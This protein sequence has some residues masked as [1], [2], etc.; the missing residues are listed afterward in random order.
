[1]HTIG[2]TISRDRICAVALEE[3]TQAPRI[4]AAVSV[5]CTEPFGTPGDAAVLSNALREALPGIPLPG[6]VVT[7][8]PALT[9]L[10]PMTLPVTDLPRARAIHLAELEGNL[11][12]EDEEILSDLL[13]VPREGSGLFFAVAA[14]RSFVENV[15]VQFGAAGIRVDRVVTDPVALLLLAPEDAGTPRDGVYLSTLNDVLLLRVSGGGVTA[16]RQFPRAMADRPEELLGALREAAEGAGGA[17]HAVFLIGETPSTLSDALPDAER[18]PPPEGVSPEHLAAYGAAMAPLRP[19]VGGGFSLRT[20][21]EAALERERDRRWKLITGVAA[22]V[23]ALLALGAFGFASWTEGEKAARARALVRKEFAAV[24][25]DVRNVVQAGSQIRAKL[26]SLRREQKELGTDAPPPAD[27]L[28][29]ASHA[30]PKGEIAV[31][32]ISI[33]GNRLRVEGD[34]GSDARLVETFRAG[35][36][37]AFGPDFSATVQESGGSVKGTSVKFTILVEKNL[38]V[39]KK[40][41]RRAS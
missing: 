21:A 34:A 8:P 23:A 16:A 39:E 25:P 11:P 31:R 37:S 10:R 28:Q 17:P 20:S 7:L 13:P 6:A 12:I 24:A 22:G 40:G 41:E 5:T 27:M 14:R 9:F 1:M 2:I 33:E 18:V 3:S 26:D 4:A 30:L 36:A 15:S 29:L 19:D 38:V 32:E 35:L